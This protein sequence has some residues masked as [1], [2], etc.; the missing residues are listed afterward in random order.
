MTALTIVVANVADDAAAVAPCMASVVEQLRA[1]DE[2]V[3][4]DAAGLPCPSAEGMTVSLAGATDRGRLYAAG[5]ARTSHSIVAFTDSTTALAP[6][7]RVGAARALARA[8]VAGGPVHAS[9]PRSTAGWAGFFVEYGPHAVA[10]YT[11][12]RGDVAAN[13]VVYDRGA[14][15]AVLAPGEPVWK[16]RV[17]ERLR[18]R[19]HAPTVIVDMQVTVTRHYGRADLTRGRFRS[20]RLYGSQRAEGWGAGRRALAVLGCSVLPVLAYTRLARRIRADRSL[21]GPF[22]RSTAAVLVAT[23]CWS[24]GEA[25]GYWSGAAGSDGVF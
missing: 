22:L 18:A 24:A 7:W 15:E 17:N 20:G 4:V 23:V 9:R 1:G 8:G 25:R 11:S 21:R 12:G 5:L 19:G 10:P 13:N 6:G 16:A 14:L 3:W 2:L